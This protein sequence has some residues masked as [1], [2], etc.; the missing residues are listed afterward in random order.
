ML[1]AVRLQPL[2][3]RTERL[4]IEVRWLGGCV[5]V[6]PLITVVTVHSRGRDKYNPF[7]RGRCAGLDDV[8]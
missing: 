7:E 5:F 6:H 8:L 3:S 1:Y 2:L 4:A